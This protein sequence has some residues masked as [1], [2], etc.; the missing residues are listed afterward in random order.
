[1][2]IK[3]LLFFTALS[4]VNAVG[5]TSDK[6]YTHDVAFLL[7]A[8]SDEEISR[9]LTL[10]KTPRD[11]GIDKVPT[12]R[13]LDAPILHKDTFEQ[14]FFNG[15]AKDFLK[16]RGMSKVPAYENWRIVSARFIPCAR[17]RTMIDG[18]LVLMDRIADE[19][20]EADLK[21]VAQLE[22]RLV[23]QPF[24]DDDRALNYTIHII[25]RPYRSGDER[26]FELSRSIIEDLRAIK[27]Q[28][29]IGNISKFDIYPKSE[30]PDVVNSL[31]NHI[32]KFYGGGLL[33][34]LAVMASSDKGDLV[35]YS[36]SGRNPTSS[37]AASFR[38]SNLIRPEKGNNANE[39]DAFQT[40]VF[41]GNETSTAAYDKEGNVLPPTPSKHHPSFQAFLSAHSS[42]DSQKE[43]LS[44]ENP[45]RFILPDTDCASCHGATSERY[46]VGLGSLTSKFSVFDPAIATSGDSKSL[47]QNKKGQYINF[48]YLHTEGKNRAV[49]SQRTINHAALTA[50]FISKFWGFWTAETHPVPELGPE[51]LITGL[52]LK[53]TKG[54]N[55]TPFI[56]RLNSG[57]L[58]SIELQNGLKLIKA[59][60]Q[61][62]AKYD[63][64]LFDASESLV[65][66]K[67][68][69]YLLGGFLGNNGEVTIITEGSNAI[70]IDAAM[71]ER[72]EAIL[73]KK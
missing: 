46:S 40:V 41:A 70:Q 51:N 27:K 10:D 1:M 23:A 8:R 28:H 3:T 54:L 56:S 24:D 11:L 25:S 69:A 33:R 42:P 17:P 6:L 67:E 45:R 34:T 73:T 29:G 9:L 63:K 66:S 12:N 47:V 21:T 53:D 71:N 68:D 26:G 62:I 16:A 18:E 37:Q 57:A 60:K 32:V 15:E 58:D 5:Q 30:N 61:I 2:K 22:H 31:N 35:F 50:Q 20:T 7:P 59:D 4:A 52:S 36:G 72:D 64:S 38:F 49:V 14:L 39:E 65:L 19:F 13:G 55:L 43:V 48:G 44:I